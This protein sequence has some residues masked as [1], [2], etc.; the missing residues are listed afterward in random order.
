MYAKNF[1]SLHLLHPKYFLTWF[2]V[3][4]LFLLV[5]L[6]YSWLLFLGKRL[7]LLSRFFVKR[8]VSIIKRNLELCFP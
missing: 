5:Q 6:P 3:F 4:I 1:F 7:W 8:R 2:G